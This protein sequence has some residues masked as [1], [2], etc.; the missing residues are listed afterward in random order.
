[1]L[2]ALNAMGNLL[3]NDRCNAWSLDWP[4]LRYR[5]TTAV[6]A[7]LADGRYAPS[8]ANRHLTARRGVL[9]ECSAVL[10]TWGMAMLISPSAVWIGF[11]RAPLREPVAVGVRS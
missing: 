8:T 5:H 11:G 6:R 2:A 1:M 3:S 10:R 9:K 4:Q 7:L